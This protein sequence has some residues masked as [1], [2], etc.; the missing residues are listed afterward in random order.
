MK[1][2]TSANSSFAL[3]IAL[4]YPVPVLLQGYDAED[5]FSAEPVEQVETVQGV[6]GNLS[7]GYVFNPMKMTI[8]IM[9]DSPSLQVFYDW[10][11]YQDMAKDVAPA[12]ATIIL[13]GP[14][15]TFILSRGFLT[16]PQRMPDAKKLLKSSRFEITWKSI[17][18]VPK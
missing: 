12:T 5:T 15:L 11:A 17:V 1:T 6:D 7:A 10:A 14:G 18:G 9:A 3:A 16:K 8:N 13:P 4:V 2:I